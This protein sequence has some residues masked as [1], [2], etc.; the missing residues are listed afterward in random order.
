MKNS[1]QKSDNSLSKKEE[2]SKKIYGLEMRL[3]QPE[4]RCSAEEISRLLSENFVE[5]CSSGHVWKYHKGD[6]IDPSS[7][8]SIKY[9]ISDFSIEILSDEVLLARYISHKTDEKNGTKTLANRSSIWKLIEN[10]WKMV[11]HQGTPV[12]R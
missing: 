11:F 9:D 1:M 3:L 5:F 8:S 2:L 4:I 6:V 7:V 10:R 12:G